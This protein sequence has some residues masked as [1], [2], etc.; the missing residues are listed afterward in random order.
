[1]QMIAKMTRI[2][3]VTMQPIEAGLTAGTDGGEVAPGTT[4]CPL[5]MFTGFLQLSQ[6]TLVS[7]DLARIDQ[8]QCGQRP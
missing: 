7:P 8:L 1:M 6:V 3:T 4:N 5:R 2:A